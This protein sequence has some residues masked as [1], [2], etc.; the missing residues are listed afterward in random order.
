LPNVE[1]CVIHANGVKGDTY[2]VLV[3]G[4]DFREV[5]AI[6]EI[7]PNKTVFNNAGTIAEVT[8]DF[9]FT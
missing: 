2:Q 1:R 3:E 9:Q 4:T 8:K 5:M 7:N 6:Y